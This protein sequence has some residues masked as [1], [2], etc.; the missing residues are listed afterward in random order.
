MSCCDE[1]EILGSDWRVSVF[2]VG[3]WQSCDRVHS[4]L[5]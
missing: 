4:Y 5:P 2:D 1:Q 3:L